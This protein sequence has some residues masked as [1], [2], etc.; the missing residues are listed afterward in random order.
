ML[1]FL[2]TLKRT[3]CTS[4]CVSC[5]PDGG[6]PSRLTLLP[7]SCGSPLIPWWLTSPSLLLIPLQ[8]SRWSPLLPGVRP[9]EH[10]S[11]CPS[12]VGGGEES[13]PQ[14][15]LCAAAAAGAWRRPQAAAA[16]WAQCEACAAQAPAWQD[17]HQRSRS[18]LL[19]ERAP[20]QLPDWQ[21]ALPVLL[22]DGRPQVRHV[23]PC[24]CYG[25]ARG[26]RGSSLGARG[27]R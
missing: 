11:G 14:L 3:K 13:P 24:S 19:Q 18:D 5:S 20:G 2:S 12:A 1:T 4:S 22:R 16:R 6:V 26:V 15:Q 25:R 8:L 10:S 21:Q 17:A 23:H 27:S 7:I 9:R